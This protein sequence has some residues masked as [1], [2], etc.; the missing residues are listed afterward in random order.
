MRWFLFYRDELVLTSSDRVPQGDPCPVALPPESRVHRLPSLEGEEC[1]AVRLDAP[2]EAGGLRMVDLRASFRLLDPAAYG[3]AGK[4]RE[5][6][7]WDAQ[8]RFCSVCGAPMQSH[9]EISKRC[10][11][12]GRE[13]WPPLSVAII[14][15]VTRREG[16]ELLMVQS[17]KFKADYMGLVAGFVET[18]ET[19]EECVAREVL[20]ETGLRVGHI[21]Y[22][23]SQPWPYPSGLMAGFKAE[24]Q[25]GTFRLQR[26][27]L[28]KGGWY[29]PDDLRHTMVPGRLSMARMLIDDW[30]D[31]QGAG[32]IKDT[33]KD[34]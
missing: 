13:V 16:R 22:F 14:V 25:G 6:L 34:F 27:E 11:R 4:A 20:E 29:T 32:N 17:R 18:G 2:V 23:A 8:S 9:T 15:A 10:T 19:L 7:H 3:M 24:C 28:N 31:E 33:L 1:R 21:R 12:C 5:I 26:S 30:L